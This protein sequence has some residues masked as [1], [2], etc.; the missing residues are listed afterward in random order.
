MPIKQVSSSGCLQLHLLYRTQIDTYLLVFIMSSNAHQHRSSNEFEVLESGSEGSFCL[1]LS[2]TIRRPVADELSAALAELED[3]PAEHMRYFCYVRQE[4][5]LAKG[6]LQ[7]CVLYWGSL[8]EALDG[9]ICCG[10]CCGATALQCR[11]P[12][13]Q[14]RA[15]ARVGLAGSTVT[16]SIAAA[17]V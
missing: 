17:C 1:S 14:S 12:A 10:A 8:L 3:A 15:S 13:P 9:T 11:A 5:T 2:Q 6:L 7:S 4:C 16:R